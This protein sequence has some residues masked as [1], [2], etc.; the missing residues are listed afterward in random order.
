MVSELT[1]VDEIL[2]NNYG[3]STTGA[4]DAKMEINY[5]RLQSKYSKYRDEN[6]IKLSEARNHIIGEL[7]RVLSNCLDINIFV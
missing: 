4:L 2:L 1:S 7:N 6:D 5:R 3:A